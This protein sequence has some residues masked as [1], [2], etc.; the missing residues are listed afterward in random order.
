MR[1]ARCRRRATALGRTRTFAPVASHASP[2]GCYHA[3]AAENTAPSWF[4]SHQLEETHRRLRSRLKS[5][6]VAP[7]VASATLLRRP[8]TS[9]NRIPRI[10]IRAS[11][12]A[13]WSVPRIGMA[14]PV[15]APRMIGAGTGGP[16]R[17]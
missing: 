15:R 4:T 5:G 11:V 14:A 1:G 8:A 3:A 7:S 2:L 10:P 13:A 17:G 16:I 9:P 12:I 6:S